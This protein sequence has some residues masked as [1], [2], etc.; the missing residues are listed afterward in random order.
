MP[1]G[2][3]VDWSLYDHIIITH[4]PFLT[5]KEFGNRYLPGISPKT[6]GARARKL[7]VRHSSYNPTDEHKTKIAA[8]LSKGTPELV[9]KLKRLRNSLSIRALSA[10]LGVSY[11][12]I[13]ILIKE[14]GI[15]LSELGKQRARRASTDGSIGKTPWN[16]DGR[17]S[18]DTK[19]KISE[20]IRG[21]RNGWFGHKMT[22]EEKSSRRLVYLSSGIFKMREYLKSDAGILARKKSIAKLRSDEYR[23]QAS[24][25]ASELSN[26]GK[27]KHRGYGMRLKTSKGGQFTTKSTYETRY[28]EI[29]QEDTSVIAF[30]YEP[31]NIEYEFE[32]TKLYYTPDFLVSYSDGHEELIEVKPMKM[33]TWPKNQAKFRAANNKHKCFK[34]ITEKDLLMVY[35]ELSRISK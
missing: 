14:H 26:Q 3:P 7:G 23:L 28:V 15:S 4:L 34:I 13:C 5:I 6:I 10:E 8:T 32:G 20:A 9:N 30:K 18:D 22:D 1:S 17:L 27:T 11:N 16:K 21:D 2:K 12:T 29:L 31:F 25:R 33:T 19:R 24:K 35:S